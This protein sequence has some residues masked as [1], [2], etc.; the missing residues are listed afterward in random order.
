M[1]PNRSQIEVFHGLTS[2]LRTESGA[3]CY[4]VVHPGAQSI[5][6]HAHDWPT[7]VIVR[8]GSLTE[9]CEGGT[10]HYDGPAIILHPSRRSHADDIDVGGL[11]TITIT[12]DPAWLRARV[13]QLPL[14]SRGWTNA[15]ARLQGRRLAHAWA[16]PSSSSADLRELTGATL[17]GLLSQDTKSVAPQWLGKVAEIL[18]TAT[19]PSTE[20]IATS[21]G[22]HPDWFRQAYKKAVGEGV[23]ETV[24]RK[25]V[26]RAMRLARATTSSLAQIAADVGFADQSHMNRAF[27]SLC[28]R[29]PLV[30]RHEN[31]LAI[32]R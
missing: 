14:E 13:E 8:L 2:V 4:R 31:R 12:F 30:V 32:A 1:S 9:T 22:L 7:M 18:N 23:W 6:A 24:R 27:Q 19:P 17:R 11:E 25:R 16:N 21:L 29:T 10:A 28:G 5:E 26:E 3:A 20:Q 15:A